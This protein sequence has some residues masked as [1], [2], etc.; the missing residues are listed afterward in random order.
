MDLSCSMNKDFLKA[1]KLGSDISYVRFKEGN[2]VEAEI[3][4]GCSL[5]IYGSDKDNEMDEVDH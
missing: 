2:K 4:F 3:N 1:G 5:L